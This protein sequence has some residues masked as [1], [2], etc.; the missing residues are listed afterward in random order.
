MPELITIP[1]AT[2][3][4]TIEYVDPSMKLLVDRA[5]VV[6]HL[7]GVF[8]QWNIKVDDVEVISE[9][10]PSEQGVRFKLPIKRTSFFFGAA[11]CKLVR[12]DADWESA[13][14]TL[15]I[16]DAGWRTLIA[17][18]GVQAG[19]YRT[20][21][22]MHLQPKVL[23][24]IELLKPFASAPLVTLDSSP[25]KAIAS[26]IKW[27]NRRVTVDGSAHLANGLFVRLERDFEGSATF[28][29]IA[30]QLKTDEDQLFA[31]I[32]VQEDRP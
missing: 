6:D 10:K 26:V 5:K 16:L 11:H 20:F 9:G 23:P 22:A 15:K 24:Y 25:I 14:E 32:G 17:I 29:E 1:V 21:I 30:G 19:A 3:E 8:K 4:I 18:G 27:E 28:D 2:F 12:D 31:L 7:F 13:E